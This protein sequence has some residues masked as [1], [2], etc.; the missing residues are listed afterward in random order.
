M[1]KFEKLRKQ[2]RSWD[3]EDLG[4][5]SEEEGEGVGNSKNKEGWRKKKSEKEN[6]V[7]K[8]FDRLRR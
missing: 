6:W 2:R 7:F 8:K 1:V 3:F 5:E 4:N